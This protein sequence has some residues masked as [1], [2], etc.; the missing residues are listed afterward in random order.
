MG[1]ADHC[2]LRCCTPI[3]RAEGLPAAKSGAGRGSRHRS[4]AYSERPARANFASGAAGQQAGRQTTP[5]RAMSTT[6][7]P[8]TRKSVVARLRD[9]AGH[10]YPLQSAATRIGRLPDND[11][12]LED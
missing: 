10:Y 6:Y 1:E 12:T 3:R 5:K 11:I 7:T 8:L 4:R 9:A 2:L